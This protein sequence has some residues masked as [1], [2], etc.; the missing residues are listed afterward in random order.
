MHACLFRPTFLPFYL[1]QGKADMVSYNEAIRAC[2]KGKRWK[3]AREMLQ[4][5][6]DKAKI[7]PDILAYNAVLR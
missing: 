4:R 2:E 1:R 6:R 3:E 5:M 7:V